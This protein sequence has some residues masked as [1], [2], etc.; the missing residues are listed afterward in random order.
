MPGAGRDHIAVID[1][2][3]LGTSHQRKL[4]TAQPG[5]GDVVALVG[6]PRLPRRDR[7]GQSRTTE[8][9]FQRRDRTLG[10]SDREDCL[11]T[12]SNQ[13]G[14]TRAAHSRQEKAQQTPENSLAKP[15]EKR[16]MTAAT[17]CQASREHADGR[18][19][20]SNFP[21]HGALGSLALATATLVASP[22]T[23]TSGVGR[24]GFGGRGAAQCRGEAVSVEESVPVVVRVGRDLLSTGGLGGRRRGCRGRGDFCRW[25]WAS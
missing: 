2:A 18:G 12:A 3:P 14:Q 15:A 11:A 4:H 19:V 6:L 9:T 21:P 7:P 5:S 10:D 22:P 1:S 8:H 24:L 13:Q 17:S 23:S 16:P 25:R 20:R